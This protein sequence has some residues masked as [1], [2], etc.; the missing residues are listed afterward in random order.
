M[1][2]SGVLLYLAL[3]SAG[4]G[5]HGHGEP[6]YGSA[7]VLA[8]PQAPSKCPPAPA[9]VMPA[10]QAPAKWEPPVVPS[11]QCPPAPAKCEPAVAP[12][13]QCPV[14][15]PAPPAKGSPQGW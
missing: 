11:K 13:K 15:A 4:L 3:G 9:K 12:S 6:A 7:Q 2:G 14:V 5:G 10:P 8:A 1:I